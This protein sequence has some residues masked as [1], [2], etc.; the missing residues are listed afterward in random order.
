MTLASRRE[1]RERDFISKTFFRV[2]FSWKSTAFTGF[3]L[4]PESIL[5]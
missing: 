4:V 2:Q 5:T 3:F 1:P